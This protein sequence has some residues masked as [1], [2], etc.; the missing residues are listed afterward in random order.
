MIADRI[1]EFFELLIIDIT[2]LM[3]SVEFWNASANQML[4]LIHLREVEEQVRQL[5]EAK[6]SVLLDSIFELLFD[7]I[8]KLQCDEPIY[9]FD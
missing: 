7:I 9:F 5:K 3:E 8:N 1:A 2:E 4:S 6:N